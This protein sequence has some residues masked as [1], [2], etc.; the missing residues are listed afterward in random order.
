MVRF[1]LYLSIFALLLAGC[2]NLGLT[3]Q[4]DVTFIV[5]IDRSKF[6]D[7]TTLQVT[8][9]D[10]EQIKI[11]EKMAGCTV[12]SDAATG[13][14]TVTCPDGVV[15]QPLEAESFAFPMQNVASDISVTSQRVQVREAYLL[16]VSGLSSDN[17]NRASFQFYGV[18]NSAQVV[19]EEGN[20]LW[21]QTEMACP[22]A[23]P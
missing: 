17:C 21:L 6:N 13:H 12:S 5:P 19:F 1:I 7:F 22:T 23:S 16:R 8:L 9:L 20:M 11:S 14:E 4:A 3:E 10:A 18:A 15:Y 2:Q